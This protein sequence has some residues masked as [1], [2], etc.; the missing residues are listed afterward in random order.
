MDRLVP[1]LASQAASRAS[2][3]S[4]IGPTA[5]NVAIGPIGLLVEDRAAIA[6]GQG[7]TNPLKLR[8]RLPSEAGGLAQDWVDS[9]TNNPVPISHF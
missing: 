9:S 4:P 5:T 2:T 1:S 8:G 6:W 3:P 7:F